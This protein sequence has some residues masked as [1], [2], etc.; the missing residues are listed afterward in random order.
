MVRTE[1]AR[2]TGGVP[3]S[4]SNAKPI[5]QAK[6]AF[7]PQS[8]NVGDKES[9]GFG[10]NPGP[11]GSHRL[12]RAHDNAKESE[13]TGSAPGGRAT[14]HQ[15]TVDS[16]RRPTP[17]SLPGSRT[18]WAA[19]AAG[20][21]LRPALRRWLRRGGRTCAGGCR[22]PCGCR[23]AGAALGIRAQRLPALRLDVQLR[24]CQLA[25]AHIPDN[26]RRAR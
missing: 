25:T 5:Q 1:P 10:G 9:N 24:Q 2:N 26:E 18:R 11:E 21:R 8:V 4:N 19:A 7:A 12:L 13:G 16:Q 22:R 23:A 15:K 14:R 6:S 3:N 17:G 20:K